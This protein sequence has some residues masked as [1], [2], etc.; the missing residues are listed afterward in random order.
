MR[1]TRRVRS[2]RPAVTHNVNEPVGT[3]NTGSNNE[4]NLNY[5]INKYD[6]NIQNSR[7]IYKNNLDSKLNLCMIFQNEIRKIMIKRVNVKILLIS[8]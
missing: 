8:D 5:T 7:F 1:H 6:R 3:L 2:R 4:Q